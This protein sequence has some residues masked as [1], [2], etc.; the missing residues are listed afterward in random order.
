MKIAGWIFLVIGVLSFIGAAS[1]GNNVFGPC[2][3]IA[4]GG[5]LLFR[6]YNK[7]VNK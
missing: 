2:F 3:W 1:M 7:E 4:L 5:F 6:A